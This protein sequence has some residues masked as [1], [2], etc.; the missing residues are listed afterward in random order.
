MRLIVAES[1]V[2]RFTRFVPGCFEFRGFAV[3]NPTAKRAMDAV[4]A[5]AA[6]HGRSL[7]WVGAS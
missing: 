1:I 6:A 2:P 5:F 4:R 3:R 7:R